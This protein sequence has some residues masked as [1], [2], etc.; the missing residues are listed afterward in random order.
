MLAAWDLPGNAGSPNAAGEAAAAI[1][2][3]GRAAVADIIGAVPEEII[4]TSGATEANNLA[5]LGV[6]QALRT[7]GST[8]T[9]LIISAIEHKSVLE[10]ARY[11]AKS[12]LDVIQAPVDAAGRLDLAAFAD[13]VDERLLMASVMMVNNETGVV[14]PVAEA[15]ALAHRHGGLFHTDAAQA[16]GKMPVNVDGL[17]IDYLSISAHKCYGPMGVGALYRASGAPDPRPLLFGGGQQ[18]GLRPGTEP[19][20]LIAGFG[21]AAKSTAESLVQG[22]FAA[23]AHFH[24]FLNRL[25]QRQLRYTR[26]SNGHAT[27]PGGGAISIEGVDADALCTAL[28]KKVAI[29]TGSACTSGQLLNSH[30]LNAMGFSHQ[31]AKQVVRICFN[32]YIDEETASLAADEFFA[33]AARCRLA[34]G[35]HRQ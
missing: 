13:F 4:F 14:Q 35:G 33:A 1:V 30:V 17:D 12:G 8:R 31:K 9:R 5:L 34:T 2:A 29:S 3:E 21:A 26:V 24:L 20:A 27:V 25:A 15:A 7:A 6:A 10:T 18:R 32:R 22:T 11:L 16:V 19:V 28:G 23:E